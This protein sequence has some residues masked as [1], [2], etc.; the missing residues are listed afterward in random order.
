MW[1]FTSVTLTA[2]FGGVGPIER[3]HR[4][5]F[6]PRTQVA[7]LKTMPLVLSG[8][9]LAFLPSWSVFSSFFQ[10]SFYNEYC[11]LG[12]LGPVSGG[13][14]LFLIRILGR[15]NTLEK[16]ERH[17]IHFFK[18]RCVFCVALIKQVVITTVNRMWSNVTFSPHFANCWSSCK[19]QW[20]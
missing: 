14:V 1:W 12:F 2:Y 18:C 20:R 13:G 7:G 11:C 3:G 17:L 8:C 6:G 5:S 4:S 9:P 10:G 19:L 16:K 15:K